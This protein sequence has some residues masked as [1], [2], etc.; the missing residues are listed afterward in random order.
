MIYTFYSDAVDRGIEIILKEY[1]KSI[2][3]RWP[4]L[5]VDVTENLVI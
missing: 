2:H 1:L 3:V 5:F 4:S